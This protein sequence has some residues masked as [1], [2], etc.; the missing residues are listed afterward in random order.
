VP[1]AGLGYAVTALDA[2]AELLAQLRER[3]SSSNIIVG[4]LAELDALLTGAFEMIV[5]MG[6]TIT[7]LPSKIAVER[8]NESERAGARSFARR[9]KAAA[10]RRGK[11]KAELAYRLGGIHG[12]L[13][14]ERALVCRPR[15]TASDIRGDA[16]KFVQDTRGPQPE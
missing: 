10:R 3:C 9:A 2:S 12:Q 4:D 14:F 1:L 7:H 16:L 8:E 6:D 15:L 13:R 5:C 11:T